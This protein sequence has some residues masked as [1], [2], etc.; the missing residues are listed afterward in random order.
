[1]KIVHKEL[2][3]G[4]WQQLTLCEQLAN[5]GS[6]VSRVLRWK[7]KDK[8]NFEGAVSRALELFDL[9]LQDPQWRGRLREIGRAREVFLDAVSGGR[10]YKSSLEEL[11]RYFFYFAYCARQTPSSS[12]IARAGKS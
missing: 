3:S 4:R 6:E 5:I 1:M 2:A 7:N 11:E 8:K 9:T 12:K 10:E